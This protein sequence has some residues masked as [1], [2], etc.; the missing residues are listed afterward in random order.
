MYNNDEDE[1]T[2]DPCVIDSGVYDGIRKVFEAKHEEIRNVFTKEF[3]EF[4]LSSDTLP[5]KLNIK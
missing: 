3:I 4:L 2:S 5:D 1:K